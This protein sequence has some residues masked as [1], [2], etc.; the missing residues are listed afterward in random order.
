MPRIV[1]G[2]DESVHSRRAL[3]WAM[4]EAALR[5]TDL[6]V[7]TVIPAMA[8][9]WSSRQLTVP[10]EP[11][12]VQRAR[13]AVDEAVA[14]SLGELGADR[15]DNVTVEVLSGYPARLLTAASKEADLVVL[16]SHGASGFSTFLLGSVSNQVA[17]HASCPVVIVP[18]ERSERSGR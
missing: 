16:G 12:I 4:R 13:E 3:D 9:P 8:S 17:H 10:D 15:P 11:E 18:A 14:K 1:V 2:V 5:R 6:T 7:L